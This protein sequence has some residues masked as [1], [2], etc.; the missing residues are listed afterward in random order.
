[1]LR[2]FHISSD[3]D[4]VGFITYSST[5]T[6]GFRF[7]A[8]SGRGYTSDGVKGIIDRLIHQRGSGRRIDLALD[9]ANR[10]L[11]SPAGG[12]R[13]H[14]RQ[15]CRNK[16]NRLQLYSEKNHNMRLHLKLMSPIPR[17]SSLLPLPHIN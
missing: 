13:P 2:H 1:M 11:F 9:M 4:H 16:P 15:V 6:V 10:D 14:T 8:L 7:N 5:P 12:A 17:P 3:G